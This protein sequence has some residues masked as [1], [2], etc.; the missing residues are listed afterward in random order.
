MLTDVVSPKVTQMEEAYMSRWANLIPIIA[1][2][3]RAYVYFLNRLR[4]DSF[5]AMAAT[6][7]R[8][9]PVTPKQAD[10]IANFVSVFTGRGRLPGDYAMASQVLNDTFFAPRY[11]V[12]RFQA[13]TGQP[14]RYAKDPAV[15]ALIAGEYARALIGYGVVYGLAS[16]ALKEFVNVEYDPRSTDFGKVRIGDTRIDFLSGLSQPTVLM[17]RLGLTALGLPSY[18]TRTGELQTLKAGGPRTNRIVSDIITDFTRSKLAPMPAA[19]WNAVEGKKVTGEPTTPVQELANMLVPMT[20]RDVYKAI[21][22]YGVAGGTALG[23]IAFFG[24]SVNTYS[25]KSTARRRKRHRAR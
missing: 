1:H 15:R 3:Q 22:K 13:L 7:S 4:A 19:A 18:K 6:L 16:T 17:T 8:E 23:L 10:Y 9:G 11:V 2:S 20:G 21:Q 14:L 24:D 25:A 12:S 5:D